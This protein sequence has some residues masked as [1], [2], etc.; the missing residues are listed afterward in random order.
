MAPDTVPFVNPPS[1]SNADDPRIGS[2]PADLHVHTV[3]SACAEVE[4]IP[5]LI[6]SQALS[7]GLRL[8]AV[9]DHNTGEN[10][11]A[12]V[13]AAR[14]TGLHV[15]PGMEL[16]TRE[17]VHLL[18][19]FDEVFPLEAWQEE[20]FRRLPPLANR[21]DLFGPQWV[22]DATG[23]WIRTEER[24]LAVSADISLEEAVVRVRR[25]GGLPVPAHVDRPSFSLFANLGLVPPGLAISALE[26]SRNFRPAEGFIRRPQLRNWPLLA[27]G[28]AHRLEDL[29]AVTRFRIV[30]PCLR[31][32]EMALRGQEGRCFEVDWPAR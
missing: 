22:V 6:V 21:E 24:L 8:L 11:A 32:I 17:E 30:S 14:N 7:V 23:E 25:L 28:D 27:S 1:P 4:M 29:R 18:C 9:T 10:A 3:L 19:L 5:P 31:E 20:V 13:E 15:L 12:M 26:V 16:Q 2:F